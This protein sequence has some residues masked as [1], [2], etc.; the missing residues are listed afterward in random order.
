MACARSRS[1]AA[2]R[3]EELPRFLELINQAR[4]LAADAGDDL[5]TLLWEQEYEFIQYKFIEFFGE[6]GGSMP[7]VTGSYNAG[8]GAEETA[9]ASQRHEQAAEEAP[10]RP[11]GVVDVEDFDSTLYFLDEREINTIA[12]EMEEE[13]RRDVRGAALSALFDLFELEQGAGDPGRDPRHPRA[14]LSQSPQ[15]ARF[16]GRR[17]HHS[18]VP[19]PRASERQASC[20]STSSGWTA[21]VSRLSEPAIVSQLI[22][23]LDEAAGMAAEAQ[24]AE[25]LRELRASALEPI[26]G[27]AAESPVR[28]RCSAVL[29]GRRRSARRVAHGRGRADP[30]R[31]RNRPRSSRSSACAGGSISIRPFPVSAKR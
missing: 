10:P 4:F 27:V 3:V 7:E 11:K 28:R 22:Q 30:P 18:R 26:L 5:L 2:R 21:F 9:Q 24:V 15:C 8:G 19:R 16:P 20:R 17:H 31:S 6:G 12:A 1:A 29:E 25:V 14:A 13:Y 23:S